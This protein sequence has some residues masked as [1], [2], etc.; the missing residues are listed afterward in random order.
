MTARSRRV[1]AALLASLGAQAACFYPR[2]WDRGGHAN[3]YVVDGVMI[4]VGAIAYATAPPPPEGTCECPGSPVQPLGGATFAV[5]AVG[6]GVNWI[7][8]G[9]GTSL[10]SKPPDPTPA[11]DAER[12][13]RAAASAGNCPAVQD[14][15]ARLLRSDRDRAAAVMGE[16]AIRACF[17]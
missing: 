11:D 6:A 16:P 1:C 2:A 17:R 9:D 3:A 8:S 7:L 5:G 14:A 10:A 12:D 15:M 13:A 4:V